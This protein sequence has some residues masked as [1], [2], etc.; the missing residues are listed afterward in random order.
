MPDQRSLPLAGKD[1]LRR[2][3]VTVLKIT[4]ALIVQR[5]VSAGRIGPTMSEIFLAMTVS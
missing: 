2:E 1:G 4:Y 5:E 3:P